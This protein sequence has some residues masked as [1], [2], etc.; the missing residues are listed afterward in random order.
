MR[1]ADETRTE[2][3]VA[4]P[5][6]PALQTEAEV[7][8]EQELASKESE[9][10]KNASEA[11]NVDAQKDDKVQNCTET[12]QTVAPDKAEVG[13]AQRMANEENQPCDDAN[14]ANES[15]ST[16]SG[17]VQAIAESKSATK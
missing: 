10:P 4:S 12:K 11:Q 3:D 1:K 15:A 16:A 8:E 13:K 17:E 2:N 14:N 5:K 9:V 6:N 7:D